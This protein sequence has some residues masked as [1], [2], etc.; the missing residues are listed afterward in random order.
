MEYTCG[1]NWRQVGARSNCITYL[2]LQQR[3][4]EYMVDFGI[5]W[6]MWAISHRANA[7]LHLE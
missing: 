2:F 1:I 3:N 6:K 7:F 5:W 4:M